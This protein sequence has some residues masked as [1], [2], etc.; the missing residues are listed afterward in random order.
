MTNSLVSFDG[1]RIVIDIPSDWEL[2]MAQSSIAIAKKIDGKGALNISILR[3]S[4]SGSGGANELITAFARE[5]K[6][7]TTNQHKSGFDD[8]AFA[9]FSR[10]GRS[11]RIWTFISADRAVIIT[12]N[13]RPEFV[14]MEELAVDEVVNS[15]RVEV[16][17]A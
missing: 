8:F 3:R 10:E 14:G 1:K 7:L 13:C 6:S 16:N 5:A 4:Q 17:P 11:W 2:G 12:Y 9:N 15:M